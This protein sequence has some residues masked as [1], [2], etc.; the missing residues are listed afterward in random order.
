MS[1]P[2]RWLFAACSYLL[3]FHICAAQFPCR[4]EPVC[5]RSHDSESCMR[6]LSKPKPAC[7]GLVEEVVLPW[8]QGRDSLLDKLCV[9]SSEPNPNSKL[10]HKDPNGNPIPDTTRLT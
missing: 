6:V 2:C 10:K 3:G 4:S 9:P 5:R 1:T 7:R 8:T